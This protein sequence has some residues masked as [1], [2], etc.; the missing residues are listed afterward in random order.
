MTIT[1]QSNSGIC[2]SGVQVIFRAYLRPRPTEGK[3]R[4]VV[5]DMRAALLQQFDDGERG[6]LAQVVDVALV[7]HA[8]HQ[9]A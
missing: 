4:I 8:E 2:S 1:T 7:G 9:D 5:F 6:R 3:E